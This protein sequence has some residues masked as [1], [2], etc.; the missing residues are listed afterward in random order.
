MIDQL[1]IKSKIYR[2]SPGFDLKPQSYPK[3]EN[4]VMFV[5][6]LNM[7]K[8]MAI[9]KGLDSLIEVARKIPDIEF[10]VVGKGKYIDNVKHDVPSNLIF[11]GELFGK[12]LYDMYKRAAI[13]CQLSLSD[14]FGLAIAEAM[15]SGCAILATT[16]LGQKGIIAKQKDIPAMIKGIKYLKDNPKIVE[17]MGRINIELSKQFNWEKF[18]DEFENMYEEISA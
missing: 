16:D 6:N 18:L 7:D 14:G 10:Y 2:I 9:G 17:K 11:T 15:A 8:V 12:K 3:K 13:Y 4:F 1:N 5:G